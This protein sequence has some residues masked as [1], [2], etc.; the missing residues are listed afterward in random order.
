MEV[1][2]FSSPHLVFPPKKNQEKSTL[3]RGRAQLWTCLQVPKRAFICTQ[4]RFFRENKRGKSLFWRRR[5]VS[6]PPRLFPSP[7]P[8]W[9]IVLSQN[10]GKGKGR[11]AEKWTGED[12]GKEGRKKKRK[13]KRGKRRGGGALATAQSQ[14]A[15]HDFCQRYCCTWLFYMLEFFT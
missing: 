11:A 12:K 8:F 1:D 13:K 9:A 10:G 14:L 6:P 15:R 2:D 3:K 5:R 4:A 7:P